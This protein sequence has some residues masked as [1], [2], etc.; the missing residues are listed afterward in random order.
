MIEYPKSMRA[1]AIFALI[2]LSQYTR[3]SVAAS[4]DP[5]NISKLSHSVQWLRLLHQG[6]P[7]RGGNFYFSP[8]GRQD[9]EAELRASIRAMSEGGAVG[10]LKQHPQCA[11]PFR[12]RF[13]KKELSLQTLDVPCPQF[14]AFLDRVKA[15]SVTLVFSS[16]YPNNPGSMFGHTFLRINSHR[17]AGE[18]KLDL[19]D[20]GISYA[21][22]VGQDDGGVTFALLGIFGGYYGAF[23]LVPY[24]L[25]VN[26]Y[27][28]AES[29]DVWEYDLS[30]TRQETF[31]LIAHAWE[32]ENNSAAK[33]YFI[34][35]NCS[36]VLLT[37][38]EAA[39]P[40]WDLSRFGTHVVPS[41][42]VKRLTQIPGAV[43]AVHFDLH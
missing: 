10:K 9:P 12:Y 42:T 5:S 32:L 30:L 19:L 29:R 15:D 35:E 13:L 25:K 36:Y 4:D 18:K 31:D 16:A 2:C 22:S 7:D 20:Y 33:Y 41:E 37:L 38:I 6:Q 8:V 43:T 26:E 34:D 11:F 24:Y 3:F 40:E 28:H 1:F 27:N 39:K 21:A 23:S 14:Q 17:K